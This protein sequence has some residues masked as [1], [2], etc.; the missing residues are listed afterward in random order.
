MKYRLSI[1]IILTLLTAGIALSE[2]SQPPSGSNLGNV[3]G[4]DF[5]KAHG[6][7][8]AKC[9]KCHSKEKIDTAI[10]SGK[11]MLNIQ[12]EMEKRGA[13]LNSKER[14]VLG[15]YWKQATPLK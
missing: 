15:I 8:D 3:K 12:K 5:K 2:V 14:D 13:T 4:G 6:I 1:S 9:T 10:T 7:I 11:D